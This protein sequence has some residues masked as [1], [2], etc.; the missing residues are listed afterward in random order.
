ML[1]CSIGL[2]ALCA[3]VGK[4]SDIAKTEKVLIVDDHPA[5]FVNYLQTQDLNVTLIQPICSF[6]ETIQI[7]APPLPLF[8]YTE[9]LALNIKLEY[10]F[11]AFK[12]KGYLKAKFHPWYLFNPVKLC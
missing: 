11:A 10:G 3:D 2:L 6:Q 5:N 9:P 7:T 4:A 1:L 12:Q 8:I